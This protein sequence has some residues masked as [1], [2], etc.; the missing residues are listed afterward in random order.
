MSSKP[1]DIEEMMALHEEW[2]PLSYDQDFYEKSVGGEFFSL[3]ATWKTDQKRSEE[4]ILGMITISTG[5]EHH[6]DAIGHVLGVECETAC[7]SA[8]ETKVTKKSCRD[9]TCCF[10]VPQFRGTQEV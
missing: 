7:Q 1:Q 8:E 5:C 10:Q 2:F 9:R 4:N 6:W 3:V